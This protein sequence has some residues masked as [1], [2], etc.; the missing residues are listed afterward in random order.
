MAHKLYA[1]VKT[2]EEETEPAEE[3]TKEE[4]ETVQSAASWEELSPRPEESEPNLTVF[5]SLLWFLF[6][7]AFQLPIT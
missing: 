5:L 3:S 1:K 7:V 2:E 4:E 6:L